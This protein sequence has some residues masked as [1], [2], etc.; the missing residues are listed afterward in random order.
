MLAAALV[1]AAIRIRENRGRRFG[2]IA[3]AIAI[4]VVYSAWNAS[5]NPESNAVERF[6]FLEYGLI[7][8]LFYRAWRPLDDLA[9]FLLPTLAGDHRRDRRRVAAVVHPQPCR[10]A[11]RHLP[12]SRGDRLRP[13]LQRRSG[14]SGAVRGHVAPVVIGA[15]TAPGRGHGAR[16][17]GFLPQRASRV[18]DRGSR[19]RVLYVSLRAGAVAGTAGSGCRALEDP[20]ATAGA[21]KDLPRRSVL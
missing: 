1:A 17:C 18:R 21:S 16:A 20:T 2:A 11:A 3:A 9:I 4:A 8:W 12:E 10:R 7:T 14:S 5:D 13:P 6:H 19:N 15:R